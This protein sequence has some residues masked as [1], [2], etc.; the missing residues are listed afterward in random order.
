[1][2]DNF[3]SFPTSA[4]I[5]GKFCC[6]IQIN[7]NTNNADAKSGS[8]VKCDILQAHSVYLPI[9]EDGRTKNHYNQY[10]LMSRNVTYFRCILHKNNELGY[11]KK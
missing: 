4:P 8:D 6:K 5:F 2:S 11:K 1:M 9:Y 10:I 7:I 3:W